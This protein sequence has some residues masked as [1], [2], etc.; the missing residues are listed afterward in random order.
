MTHEWPCREGL[1]CK[2]NQE[3]K[4]EQE[5]HNQNCIDHEVRSHKPMND[6][7]VWWQIWY[8]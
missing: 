1:S 5:E 2:R 6:D 8:E 7:I 3:Q 4:Q